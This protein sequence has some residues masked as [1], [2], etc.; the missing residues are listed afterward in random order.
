[1]ATAFTYAIKFVGNMQAAIRFHTEQLGFKLRFESPDWSELDTGATTVALHK[2]SAENPAGTCKLGFR[3]DDIDAFVA[4][5]RKNGV[6]VVS[7]P[8]PIHGQRIA[9]LADPDGAVFSAS[10]R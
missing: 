5:C 1:M 9:E 8:K 6:T 3:V 7:E 10:G 4:A 2:A